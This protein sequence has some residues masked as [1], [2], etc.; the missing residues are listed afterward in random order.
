MFPKV[1]LSLLLSI[2]KVKR[3]SRIMLKSVMQ[4]KVH[5]TRPTGFRINFNLA[6]LRR[7]FNQGMKKG[8]MLRMM[9]SCITFGPS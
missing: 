3:L 1:K 2:V 7:N 4:S 6:L 8:R 5:E 9:S